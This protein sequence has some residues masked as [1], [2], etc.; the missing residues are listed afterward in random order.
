[1][2][3]R[4]RSS[5]EHVPGK[6]DGEDRLAPNGLSELCVRGRIVANSLRKQIEYWVGVEHCYLPNRDACP[7]GGGRG[8]RSVRRLGPP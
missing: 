3:R 1:M 7:K 6:R 8:S 2:K 5:K 4:F